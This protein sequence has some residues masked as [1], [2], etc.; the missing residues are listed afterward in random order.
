MELHRLLP[1]VRSIRR[2]QRITKEIEHDVGHE[3]HAAIR[4]R[5]GI[6]VGGV[7]GNVGF[8]GA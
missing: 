6:D 7:V 3:K 8:E 4:K 2:L 1:N 5:A